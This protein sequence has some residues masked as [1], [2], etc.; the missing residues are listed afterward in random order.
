[1]PLEIKEL[2]IKVTATDKSKNQQSTNPKS[3]VGPATP[4]QAFLDA[5]VEKIL[6]ILKQRVER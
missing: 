1:M 4:D 6:D 5:C 2:H 3:Q